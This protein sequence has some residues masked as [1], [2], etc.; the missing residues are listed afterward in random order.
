MY[1]FTSSDLNLVVNV[2]WYNSMIHFIFQAQWNIHWYKPYPGP[3]SKPQQM[4]T[5]STAYIM[6]Y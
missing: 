1:I 6:F 5:T 3:Q 4:K 2:C